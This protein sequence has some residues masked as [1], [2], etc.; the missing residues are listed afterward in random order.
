MLELVVHGRELFDESTCSFYN[1]GPDVTI[2]L[3]HSLLSLTKWES[4]WH[5]PFLSMTDLAQK[6][7]LTNEMV[8]DY[9]NCMSLDGPISLSVLER[10]TDADIQTI[11]D[12]IANPMTATWFSNTGPKTGK[13]EI[14]T[15]ELIYYWMISFGIPFECE[16][17]HLNRLMTLIRV[18]NEKN[19]PPKKMSKSELMARN[20]ALNKARRAKHGTK[21]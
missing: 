20:R 18:C 4:K 16:K 6:K 12:Y 3:E 2:R 7:E 10:L 9:F 5:K 15:S 19:A 13:K 11:N 14:V 1:E 8:L 17:W 21:G